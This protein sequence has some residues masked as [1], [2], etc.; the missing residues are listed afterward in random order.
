MR[1]MDDA[2][3]I[4]ALHSCPACLGRDVCPDFS[5]GF[6]TMSMFGSPSVH[7]LEYQGFLREEERLLVI[8]PA[9]DTWRAWDA[10]I[11]ANSSQWSGCL[12]NVAARDSFLSRSIFL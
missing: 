11:C 6:L 9:V 2:L 1:S 8:S 12:V 3:S 5:Q 7:G 4:S 10:K